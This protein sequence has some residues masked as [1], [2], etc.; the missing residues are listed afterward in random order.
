MIFVASHKQVNLTCH[1]NSYIILWPFKD[2][3]LFFK[4]SNKFGKNSNVTFRSL[5]HLYRGQTEKELRQKEF[6]ESGYF[7]EA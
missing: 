7:N 3:L 4:L 6:Y 5:C 1:I 2:D